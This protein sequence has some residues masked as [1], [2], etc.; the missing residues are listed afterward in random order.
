MKTLKKVLVSLS[1]FIAV[2]LV[3]ALFGQQKGALWEAI[4][5][6][7]SRITALETTIS[8]MQN[9]MNKLAPINHNHDLQYSSLAHNHD[10]N[11]ASV[12]HTH[13]H[14][15]IT[16]KPRIL[17]DA[18]VMALIVDNALIRQSDYDSGWQNISPGWSRCFGHDLGGDPDEYIVE[19][20]FKDVLGGEIH[21][22]FYGGAYDYQ[23][24]NQI[25]G[26]YW[27]DLTHERICVFRGDHDTKA[28]QVRIRI[29][30]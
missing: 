23:I 21:H 3:I 6:L 17:S 25:Y 18:D 2:I 19:L 16:G 26:A 5:E 15:A 24:T 29:W 28:T 27:Y 13:H 4:N 10:V 30:K 14:E 7:K 8:T 11:Y 20:K 12:T 1:V 9:D 22:T